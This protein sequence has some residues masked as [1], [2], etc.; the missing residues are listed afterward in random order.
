MRNTVE[1][2]RLV[3]EAATLTALYQVI[4]S[5]PTERRLADRTRG[6][7]AAVALRSV[8][9]GGLGTGG[10]GASGP[11]GGTGFSVDGEYWLK[12]Y[13]HSFRRRRGR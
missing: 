1:L 12:E 5:A 7:S 11:F 8:A 10:G 4:L 6:L 3:G 2:L 9:D 13:P